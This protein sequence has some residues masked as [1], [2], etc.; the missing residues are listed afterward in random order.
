MNK[1]LKGAGF[2]LLLLIIIV[3]IVEFAGTPTETVKELNFSQVYKYLTEENISEIRFVDSTS[4]EGTIKDSKEKFTSYMPREVMS[5][6]FANEVLEQS[7]E[8]KLVFSGKPKPTEPWYIQM[9]PTLLLIFFMV[10]MWFLFMNQSQG[11]GG[12]VMNF[13]KSKARVHKDD[14]KTRVTFKDVAG[15]QEEKEDLSEVVDF[16]KNPKRYIEDLLVQVK[17]I[18]QEQLLVKQEFHSSL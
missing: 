2:Y 16:L 10:I 14:E 12:K 5:D 13:G 17:L 18:Y 4:V 11:G 15:L 8:G 1:F 7:K 6:E 3:T 9:L